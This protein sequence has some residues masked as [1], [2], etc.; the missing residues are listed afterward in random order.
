M[1]A[2]DDRTAVSSPPPPP[3]QPRGT[4]L[5]SPRRQ[6]LAPGW[7]LT[8]VFVGFP[9]WWALGVS[10][11]VFI[12]AAVPMAT[13]LL[14]RRPT[15]VPKGFG[16]WILFLIWIIA[17]AALL[18]ADAP[19]TQQV[20]GAGVMLP[21]AYRVAWYLACTVV[22]LYVLN[23]REQDFSTTRVARL[24][25]LLFVF[26]VIGG[27]AG[28][29]VP[30]FSF[31]SPMELI[32]PGAQQEGWI[33]AL[34]HPSV[35][36]SSEFLG[37]EQPRPSAPFAYSNAWGNNLAMLLPFFVLAW[38]GK[39]AGWRRWV[40]PLV[41]AAAVVPLVYSLNRG[42]WLG[43][44]VAAVYAALW[45]AARRRYV[46]LVSLVGAALVAML[47]VLVTPLG[48]LA[49]LRIETPHSNERRASLASTVL[50]ATAD[51]S[52]VAGYGTTR[53]LEGSFGSI[54]GANTPSCPNCVP[55]PLGTQGFLWRLLITTGFVGAGLY[56]WFV[57]GQ[58]VRFVRR[59]ST[60]ALAGT[61]AILLSVVFFFF[62]DSLESP[63]YVLMM[64][65]ALM[66]RELLTQRA[67]KATSPEPEPEVVG[68][69]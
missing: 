36:G 17:G 64:G 55:A 52:P 39:D 43:V 40:A 33:R 57:V 7:P 68:E 31:T 41:L 21:Y 56:L 62:Y 50:S 69:P 26:T 61:T 59:P 10:H 13:W 22:L 24:M 23:L 1:T 49:T 37:F 3:R 28:V 9:L 19:N 47:I 63:M 4:A 11:F 16:A 27:V 35:S 67:S 54:A 38:F 44:G 42:V 34:V 30:S 14:R 58:F 60:V 48:D 29:V 20:T 46:P 2:V 25:S 66:N 5:I 6:V 53:T 45:M 8:L 15:F 65:I 18:W 51:G 32:I 12:A